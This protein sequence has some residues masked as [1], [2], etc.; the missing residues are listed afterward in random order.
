MPKKI[1]IGIIGLGN[2]GSAVASSIRKNHAIILNNTGVDLRVKKVCDSR[3][4]KT[5]FPFTRDPNE[6]IKDPNI[7]VVVEAI[8]GVNPALKLILAALKNGKH[9]VT[10]NKEVIAKHMKE[11]LAAARK[12]RVSVM[13]EGAVGGGI[14]IILPLK[15]SLVSNKIEAVYGIVNGTTNYILSK[16][17]EEGME[18]KDAL[19]KAQEKGY[20]EPDP[21]ADIKGLDASYKAAILAAVAFG[22]DVEVSDVPVEGITRVTQEDI[23]Y[24]ND[25]GY[26]IKLLAIAQMIEG[27]LDVRVHPALVPKYHPLA[28]VSENFN[29]IYVKGQPLG[30]L[31]FYG[32]GAGGGP[33][34]SAII[35]DIIQVAKGGRRRAVK[36]KK[37][38]ARKLTDIS[39]R[40]YI[41]LQAPD[42]HGVLAGISKAFAR[43]KVSIAAVVQKE[44]VGNVATIVI[45]LHS[46]S[47]KNLAAALKTVEKLSVVKKVCNVIRIVS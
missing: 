26:V 1:N 19:K 36:L 46:V 32:P 18:F 38:R 22:A 17:R 7:S 25:I 29:A 21:T 13:F 3:K 33:T 2:I 28:S 15:E 37:I 24:A 6:I 23:Q 14:P 11:I 47:E 40:Y 45:L 10:P 31:M 9:V 8:G 20:A 43:K 16:M 44:M 35:S 30:Q 12:N 39:S 27:K 34:S 5:S 4:V 42:R 41:R